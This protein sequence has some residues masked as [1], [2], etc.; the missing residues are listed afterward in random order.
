MEQRH[1]RSPG[2]VCD[3]SF[4]SAGNYAFGRDRGDAQVKPHYA[5]F[6]NHPDAQLDSADDDINFLE[7]ECADSSLKVDLHPWQILIAD[8]DLTVHE[9]TLLALGGVRI[10]GRPLA[11][12]HAY[13]AAEAKRVIIDNPDLAL[14]LLDVV[15]ETVDAGLQLVQVIRKE[16]GLHQLRIVLRTGQP[17]YAP[18]GE[19]GHQ[20][21]IDGYTTKSQL[22]RAMLISVLSDTLNDAAVPGLPN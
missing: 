15:M 9:T 18:A 17:G 20:F 21:A 16:L 4:F 7:E 11:F 6:C 12:L 5:Y 3:N 14:I 8:D 13:S 19:V 1:S 22:T 10:H 2:L